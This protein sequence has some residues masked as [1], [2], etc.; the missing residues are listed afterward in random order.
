MFRHMQGVPQ[1]SLSKFE[2]QYP[3][4]SFNK[5]HQKNPNITL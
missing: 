3:T 5:N 2:G 4:V 1:K